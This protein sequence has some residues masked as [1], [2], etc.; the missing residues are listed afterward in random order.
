MNKLILSMGAF[1]LFNMANAQ[2][3]DISD[4]DEKCAT[5]HSLQHRHAENP[6]LAKSFNLAEKRA[7]DFMQNNRDFFKNREGTEITIPVVFHVVHNP[8]SPEQNI[9]DEMIFSQMDVLNEDFGRYNTNASETREIF[10][11]IAVD[12]KI[13]FCLASVD[14]DGNPTT[15]ITRT[16]STSNF[17]LAPLTNNIKD[18]GQGGV[19]PWPTDQ[20]LNIWVC[21]MSFAG[22]PFV[23]GYA[24][25]PGEAEDN[26]GG[27]PA[28]TDGVVMQ[29]NYV[30]R[31]EDPNTAPSNLGRT[32]THEVGHWL[33]LRHVW[34][35]GDCDSTDYVYD[36]PYAAAQSNF[37]CDQTKNTCDDANIGD[38]W[39]DI[40]A[41]DMIE[42]YMDY[43]ADACMNM[44]S[45]G[46]SERMW[47]FIMTDPRRNSLFNSPGCGDFTSVDT[48]LLDWN[49]SVFPNPAKDF[50]QVKCS[51]ENLNL[52]LFD[53]TG[54]VIY[55]EALGNKN[56]TQVN[57][58]KLQSG[59]YLLKISNEK[60][61]I[62]EKIIIQ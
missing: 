61:M 22:S 42:N 26:L 59:I 34:G 15:G 6:A 51:A 17:L 9:P 10:D 50:I 5:M 31:T 55:T 57:T 14:P 2:K 12:T 39:G 21:D 24:Q 49:V 28:N 7:M 46:Q 20:Y 41:P 32:T 16:E 58:S 29:Y 36:T 37:D 25:F 23:L 44:F 19:D 13:Q 48:K 40:D 62:T 53:L 56:F 11:S 45:R 3:L 1:M 38:F 52:T 47:S 54:K 18:S 30:G 27:G 60:H 4:L 35:D 8:N 43:S 33:G